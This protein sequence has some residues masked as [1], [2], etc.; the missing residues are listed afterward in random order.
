VVSRV[1]SGTGTRVTSFHVKYARTRILT[2]VGGTVSDICLTMCPGGSYRAPT[3][4][5][6]VCFFTYTSVLT[7][8]AAALA[9]LSFTELASK[10][11]GTGADVGPVQ[12]TCTTV[13]TLDETAHRCI[14][15]TVHH[16]ISSY[17][18]LTPDPLGVHR[19]GW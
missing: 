7:G 9:K 13:L 2:R 11:D 18:A 6:E 1:A 16:R 10:A 17:I 4:V 12:L 5:A 14:S 19:V 3:L 8:I 15:P